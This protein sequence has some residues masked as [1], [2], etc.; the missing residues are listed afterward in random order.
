LLPQL[1]DVLHALAGSQELLTLRVRSAHL[2]LLA[3]HPSEIDEM[4][5]A[6]APDLSE[7]RTQPS[8]ASNQRPT[9]DS[10]ESASAE[11]E[12]WT[13]GPTEPS[14]VASA[15][16]SDVEHPTVSL[17]PS[18]QVATQPSSTTEATTP[19]DGGAVQ[20]PRQPGALDLTH[21]DTP[22]VEAGDRN[23]NFF[24]ELDARLANLRSSETDR[25]IEH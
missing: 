7:P 13:T 2:E 14:E 6:P 25:T 4:R 10:C 1:V 17:D 19:A 3:F 18:S 5:E 8:I 22:Y 16:N 12:I 20:K 15:S 11:T 21:G 9:L 24:D 23:Y